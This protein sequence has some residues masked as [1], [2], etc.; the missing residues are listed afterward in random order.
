MGKKQ[1]RSRQEQVE[2]A[3]EDAPAAAAADNAVEEE[4]AAP[5]AARVSL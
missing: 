2:T 1:R 3:H 4:L 5:E